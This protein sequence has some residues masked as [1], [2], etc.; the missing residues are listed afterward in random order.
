MTS[1][2]YYIAR[3]AQAFGYFRKNQRMSDA[4][5]EMHLLREAE[6]QLGFL[7]WE[8]VEN[9]EELSVEY[10]NLRR[11]IKE[12]EDVNNR[13]AECQT[14]LDQAHEERA[15]VLNSIPEVHQELAE[16][17]VTLLTELEKLAHKRDE[18]VAEAR[19]VRRSYD[20]LK[21]KLEVLTKEA[22]SA[23]FD[24]EQVNK[25]KTRLGELKNRFA[26][27]KQQRIDIGAEIEAG[28][29]KVDAVDAQLAEKKKGRRIHASEAFQVIGDGNKE[30]SVLR[31]ES[32]VLDTQMRQL[33][34]EIGRFVSRHAGQH[35]PCAEA[36]SP[37]QG[38]V[39]V[40]R[41]LRRSI[42]LNH[43]LAGTA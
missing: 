39:D 1:S 2:R 11:F 42:A 3:F 22:P 7:I 21:M 29:A 14:R 35:A 25:L 24:K 37:H 10:W 28:D 16:E 30:M 36:A 40:M 41:A 31:A 43:R 38:L 20:G 17:R 23:A 13:L 4:A 9:I 32:A 27:L 6:A 18:I 12:K 34:A 8:R 26:D 15:T 19:E 33:Y 5:S